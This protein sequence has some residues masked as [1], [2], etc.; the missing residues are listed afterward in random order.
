MTNQAF[1]P[2]REHRELSALGGLSYLAGNLDAYLGDIADAVATLAR[3]DWAVVTLSCGGSQVRIM[4]STLPLAP[5]HESARSVHGQ[6]AETVILTGR[7]VVVEDIEK[8]T[9][10]GTMPS[11]Y[12]AY[13]G[14][15]LRTSRGDVLGTACA[16]SR[17]PRKFEE[18]D[19]RVVTLLAERAAT[20]IDNYQLYERLCA[21]N[22]ELERQIQARTEF[23]SVASHELRTP[24][25]SLML[26]AQGLCSSTVA[27]NPERVLRAAD[28]LARQ[29]ARLKSLIDDLLSVGRI[30]IGRLEM[31]LAP[32]D[33]VALVRDELERS[34]PV[35]RKAV[36]TVT[37]RA[38]NP[39][40]GCWDYDKVSQVVA[41]LISNA[42]KFGAGKPIEVAIEKRVDT[43]RLVVVDHGIG[44]DER[45]LPRIF[46]KFERA[47]ST[48]Y[49]YG[50]LGLGLYIVRNIVEALGGSIQA[51][52]TPNVETRFTVE[53]P[54]T[55]TPSSGR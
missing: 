20:G 50:G 21:T 26:T 11:G 49:S 5:E 25:T 39:V 9:S 6:V 51:Q 30:D 28:L 15:P 42:V 55:H 1:E 12:R 4:A 40:Q 38:D 16:F 48:R 27:S 46:E 53:L 14:V 2:G 52:S 18:E 41:N 45:A 10:K 3:V 31:Q 37:M 34:A 24:V 13:L 44:I 33:L 54:T 8:D 29:I 32:M 35:L 36:C 47:E 17:E 43:A 7:V 23:L 19:L 22:A